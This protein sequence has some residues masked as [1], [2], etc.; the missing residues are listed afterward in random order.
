MS[1][2]VGRPCGEALARSGRCRPR[3][4][5]R[6][7]AA[8]KTWKLGS[9][10]ARPS[11]S[12]R[13]ATGVTSSKR[14]AALA[15][16]LRENRRDRRVPSTASAGDAERLAP[17][18]HRLGCVRPG[19]RP[20]RGSAALLE[21]PARPCRRRR[22]MLRVAEAA[23]LR[24]RRTRR[25]R[26]DGGP[27]AMASCWR[28]RPAPVRCRFDRKG[29]RPAFL[30]IGHRAVRSSSYRSDRVPSKPHEL[31]PDVTQRAA[32]LLLCADARHDS[33]SMHWMARLI[34]ATAEG[35]QAIELRPINSLGR[36]PN[37]SIQLLDKIVSKEH[38][39]LEQRDGAVHP[40]RSRQPERHVHQ[41]RARARR[42][43]CSATATRSRSARRAP[44]TTTASRPLNFAP[45]A[46][47]PGRGRSTRS[48]AAV[49]AAAAAP[50]AAGCRRRS[51]R[52]RA[53]R[54]AARRACRRQ[55][56]PPAAAAWRRARRSPP[57]PRYPPAAARRRSRASAAAASRAAAAAELQRHARRRA[58]LGA[59]DR[60]PDRRARRRAS[61][62][63]TRSRTTRSSSGSTTSASAS[64]WELTR[65]IG[66]R[67]RHSTSSS[68]RSSSRSSSS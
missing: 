25:R 68:R 35:Q 53:W 43:G 66:A 58:R 55:G 9:R 8:T 1:G 27:P 30:F 56:M 31:Y 42:A 18:R 45:L 52:A 63:S 34:L 33:I 61:S 40:A 67:A 51:R 32:S 54:A 47:R 36:H 10:A 59:R 62:P 16:H 46:D 29:G 12:A 49:A 4:S 37:N 11:S 13:R 7:S 50:P 64:R 41:R 23:A 21:R 60:H 28:S 38:C 48:R 20:H 22:P 44:A 5:P 2:G 14:P 19:A 17:A 3:S 65:D 57:V 26:R 15:R 39:I 24:A 6:G